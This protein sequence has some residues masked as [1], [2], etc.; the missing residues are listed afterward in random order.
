MQIFVLQVLVLVLSFSW[1]NYTTWSLS[2]SS[3]PSSPT[4]SS[5]VACLVGSKHSFASVG[6]R[7]SSYRHEKRARNTALCRRYRDVGIPGK[8]WKK[9]K[10]QVAVPYFQGRFRSGRFGMV[11][12]EAMFS[13]VWSPS[14]WWVRQLLSMLFRNSYFKART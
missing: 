9:E 13:T 1:T 6:D 12:N 7:S 4:S 3:S 5:S 2:T 14:C 8:N 10:E 11:Q